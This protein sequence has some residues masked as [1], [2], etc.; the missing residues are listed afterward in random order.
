MIIKE[1][2]SIY[3]DESGDPIFSNGSSKYLVFS[4]IIVNSNIK[5]QISNEIDDIKYKFGLNE[6]KSSSRKLRNEKTRIQ[7]FK[8]INNLEFKVLTLFILKDKVL[9]EWRLNKKVFYKYTQKIINSELHKIFENKTI[10]LDRY[11]SDNYQ[12]SLKNYLDKQLDLFNET[13]IIK[14]AKNENLIQL[15]DLFS[16]TFRKFYLEEFENTT[17]FENLF[18]D[19]NLRL[20]IFPNSLFRLKFKEN[21]NKEDEELSNITISQAEQ[22]LDEIKHNKIFEPKKIVL[23]YLLFHAKYNDKKI[24]TTE[25]IDWLKFHGYKFSEENFRGNIIG[26]LRD[27]GVIIAGSRSGIKIPIS[28]KELTEYFSFTSNKVLPMIN[29]LSI[30]FDVLNSKSNGKLSILKNKNFDF[31]KKLFE[32]VRKQKINS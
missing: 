12:E 27:N 20:I 22:Y 16:G 18:N 15:A 32:I 24:Y 31:L 2:Y 5:N 10:V 7:I 23:E 6:L 11:G 30:S 14:S 21:L 8:E 19:H 1:K 28:S 13:V 29:R 4:A 25:L 26:K 3:I 9:A 17:F